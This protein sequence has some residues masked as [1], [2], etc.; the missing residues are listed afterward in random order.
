MLSLQQKEPCSWDA[1]PNGSFRSGKEHKHP[2]MGVVSY[3]RQDLGWMQ[4]KGKPRRRSST[5][6]PGAGCTSLPIPMDTSIPQASGEPGQG[7]GRRMPCPEPINYSRENESHLPYF[8]SA[9]KR[10]RFPS[11]K[12]SSV[13]RNFSKAMT[14]FQD[15]TVYGGGEP[16]LIIGTGKGERG[17]WKSSTFPSGGK[18]G[19]MAPRWEHPK[20]QGEKSTAPCSWTSPFPFSGRIKVRANHSSPI[21]SGSGKPH[22]RS[23]TR[24]CSSNG[25]RS[26]NK[27][28]KN[29]SGSVLPRVPCG[30][31][32]SW[33]QV[34]LQA[35]H[36]APAAAKR[37]LSTIRRQINAH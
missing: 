32:I 26:R 28:S 16:G 33:S 18:Q 34:M 10:H 30:D 8:L 4:Q 1:H 7:G 5:R 6:E 14:S 22:N 20:R 15:H 21:P 17:G 9:W 3:P 11:C 23:R 29:Q 12:G 24:S 37:M 13:P 36:C 25:T 19:S 27:H 35:L 31:P 2:G